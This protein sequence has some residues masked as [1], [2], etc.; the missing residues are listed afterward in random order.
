MAVEE[1]V[2]S[3]V[4]GEEEEVKERF[5]LRRGDFRGLNGGRQQGQEGVR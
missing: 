5:E 3:A 4:E 1:T 2:W